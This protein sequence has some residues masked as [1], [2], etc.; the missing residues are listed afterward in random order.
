[1][2]KALKKLLWKRKDPSKDSK[3][4][5]RQ[6]RRSGHQQPDAAEG[7]GLT[8]FLSEE[9]KISSTGGMAS[10]ELHGDVA[11]SVSTPSSDAEATTTVMMKDDHLCSSSDS[12][13]SPG[14]VSPRMLAVPNLSSLQ[15]SIAALPSSSLHH[16]LQ[17]LQTMELSGATEISD[18]S[19]PDLH[20]IDGGTETP[21]ATDEVDVFLQNVIEGKTDVLRKELAERKLAVAA[22]AASSPGL[23]AVSVPQKPKGSR[24]SSSSASF[25]RST[26]AAAQEATRYQTHLVPSSVEV[27]RRPDGKTAQPSEAADGVGAATRLRPRHYMSSAARSLQNY[28][29]IAFLGSG[30]FAEVTLARNKLTREYFAIKKIS[31]QRVKEEGCVERTFTE[32]QLLASLHHPFLVRLYQAFQSETHLYLVLDFAQGGDLYYVQQQQLWLRGMKR[33]LVKLRYPYYTSSIVSASH[34]CSA[35]VAPQ[36]QQQ[37]QSSPK[38]PLLASEK[39]QPHRS[40]P[41][42]EVS[43]SLSS[44]RLPVHQDPSIGLSTASLTPLTQ[45]QQSPSSVIISPVGPSA[46]IVPDGEAV[47]PQEGLLSDA[48]VQNRSRKRNG[49]GKNGAATAGGEKSKRGGRR[50][51]SARSTVMAASSS[52]RGAGP[53]TTTTNTITNTA[54]TTPD[55][56]SR[57]D[58]DAPFVEKMMEDCVVQ[59]QLREVCV[60]ADESHRLPLRLIAFYAVEV[61]LVLKY[62]HREGFLYRDLKP[63]NILMRGNGHIMLTDFGVAK[64]RK[65][66]AIATASCGDPQQQA[67]PSA[68]GKEERANS[69]T[70]TTHYMSP[71]MLRGLPYDSRTDWWSFGCLLFEWANGRKAFDGPNQFALFRSIVEEDVTIQPRDFTLMALEVHSRVAQLHYRSQDLNPGAL[72][73]SHVN[74][75]QQQ[76]RRQRRQS[77]AASETAESYDATLA[78]ATSFVGMMQQRHHHHHRSGM[79]WNNDS[80]ASQ[81]TEADAQLAGQGPDYR[82]RHR[83]TAEKANEMLLCPGETPTNYSLRFA[84]TD[85]GSATSMGAT[86]TATTATAAPTA[87][88]SPPPPTPSDAPPNPYIHYRSSSRLSCEHLTAEARDQYLTKSLAEMKEATDLLQNLVVGLL[89]RRVEHRMSGDAVLEHPFFQ[90][91]YI[92]S[93]MYYHIGL[94]R[95]W[96]E[97]LQQQQLQQQQQLSQPNEM[98][99]PVVPEEATGDGAAAQQQDPQHSSNTP[100]PSASTTPP[101]LTVLRQRPDDWQDLFLRQH[102]SAIYVPRLRTRDDLRYFPSAVTATGLS[103]AVEQHRRIKEA[104]E[105]Q[106]EARRA[107]TKASMMSENSFALAEK[108]TDESATPPPE[109]PSAV[110]AANDGEETSCTHGVAA[111]SL[112]ALKSDAPHEAPIDATPPPDS[113]PKA[114]SGE[115]SVSGD[116]SPTPDASSP[117]IAVVLHHLG[118]SVTGDPLPTSG[119]APV[120]S[121]HVQRRQY[122]STTSAADAAERSQASSVPSSSVAAIEALTSP[123]GLDD[124]ATGRLHVLD[125]AATL[126]QSFVD[127]ALAAAAAQSSM[128]R[129]MSSTVVEVE[130]LKSN[131]KLPFGATTSLQN[132]VTLGSSSV[133]SE[134][135]E[136]VPLVASF[137]VAATREASSTTPMGS[138]SHVV[139]VA[140]GSEGSGGSPCHHPEPLSVVDAAAAAVGGNEVMEEEEEEGSGSNALAAGAGYYEQDAM[141]EDEVVEVDDAAVSGPLGNPAD[142]SMD[143]SLPSPEP[144]PD[145]SAAASAAPMA[146]E[147]TAV[148][149][150]PS[151]MGLGESLGDSKSLISDDPTIRLPAYDIPRDGD[152]IETR[153]SSQAAATTPPVS[154][155][156]GSDDD[157]DNSITSRYAGDGTGSGEPEQRELGSSSEVSDD[158][159]GSIHNHGRHTSRAVSSLS[160]STSSSSSTSTSSIHNA[161][162]AMLLH[163]HHG[164]MMG[165]AAALVA[166]ARSTPSSGRRTFDVDPYSS[167]PHHQP[168]GLAWHLPSLPA[169]GSARGT[170]ENVYAP[171]RPSP[172]SPDPGPFDI[173][174][175]PAAMSPSVARHGRQRIPTGS[176]ESISSSSQMIS[177]PGPVDLHSSSSGSNRYPGRT[178]DPTPSLDLSNTDFFGPLTTLPGIAYHVDEEPVATPSVM[179]YSPVTGLPSTRG[180]MQQSG[181]ATGDGA[182]VYGGG[183]GGRTGSNLD[184]RTAQARWAQNQKQRIVRQ[185]H[186]QHSSMGAN[187][188]VGHPPLAPS[189]PAMSTSP[190]VL[191]DNQEAM[192]T[193]CSSSDY[194][195]PTSMT[196]QQQNE[197]ELRIRDPPIPGATYNGEDHFMSSES[198]RDSSTP[199]EYFGFTYNDMHCSSSSILR[200]NSSEE[201]FNPFHRTERHMMSPEPGDG[202]EEEE[203]EYSSASGPGR[204]SLPPTHPA[205]ISPTTSNSSHP[206]RIPYASSSSGASGDYFPNFSFSSPQFLQQHYASYTAQPLPPLEDRSTPLQ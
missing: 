102:I 50:K 168:F 149:G 171:Q 189:A 64:F 51:G 22:A 95:A 205:M 12:F 65:G 134:P 62:L 130:A 190:L 34:R 203:E 39:K 78:V 17:P 125:R 52:A 71:E 202:R 53:T 156:N 159:A 54:T 181:T 2:L 173:S 196:L 14:I 105:Q 117:L 1:M 93:Q 143:V 74:I 128:K 180:N 164:G 18:P 197:A 186:R 81:W 27:G 38:S 113:T 146:A 176:N 35:A 107:A 33:T 45:P 80:F 116:V 129:R 119:S 136:L 57:V 110:G 46:S 8:A 199:G 91:P 47:S 72:T 56:H 55:Q 68:T 98:T 49:P 106:R 109:D 147:E 142:T 25:S 139:T 19:L 108:D 187:G 96:A 135:H 148:P 30:T 77:R 175:S 131:P 42:D 86:T 153:E 161:L 169:T 44:C 163:Q 31:K 200:G 26:A 140:F 73:F 191:S 94:K 40:A 138:S 194:G 4:E 198:C 155:G 184:R 37:Q 89:D 157:S 162:N 23:T 132:Q 69:F 92:V 152:S 90:C 154:R 111:V 88:T 179:M 7:V 172:I 79:T 158:E 41:F 150:A 124:A 122:G 24:S 48:A 84:T 83:T 177:L 121:P 99:S 120:S 58:L 112:S 182:E 87:T 101:S 193:R 9:A 170:F 151:E 36:Q 115:R 59:P 60:A 188:L 20:S 82:H 141:A 137:V 127:A 3:T 63:E 32:R 144:Y 97:H 75:M 13:H 11:L 21:V 29:L 183:G 174:T 118:S 76:Q 16:Q 104:K 103:A 185:L 160:A 178:L 166:V 201:E 100:N 6:K 165:G 85:D 167:S 10:T 28:E 67:G 123:R 195:S 114:G 61:A 5:R 192:G 70:G 66:A 206:H 126:P 15:Y 133:A 204:G 145:S 43:M